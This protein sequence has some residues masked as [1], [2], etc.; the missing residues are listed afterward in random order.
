MRRSTVLSLSLQLVLPALTYRKLVFL[1]S[2]L[3]Y[4]DISSDEFIDDVELVKTLQNVSFV[5]D[6]AAVS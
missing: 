6:A 2:Y 4:D 1:F 5:A 3:N